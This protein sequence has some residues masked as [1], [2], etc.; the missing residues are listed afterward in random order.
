MRRPTPAQWERWERIRRE[1]DERERREGTYCRITEGP[2]TDYEERKESQQEADQFERAIPILVVDDEFV[3][4]ER[5]DGGVVQ[6]RI[7]G[8]RR[9]SPPK[10]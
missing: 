7:L 8:R 4:L 5:P 9:R 3:L 2:A 10:G 6:A 1:N